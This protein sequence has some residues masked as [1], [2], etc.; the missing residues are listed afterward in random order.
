[1]HRKCLSSFLSNITINI[2]I[3][4]PSYYNIDAEKLNASLALLLLFLYYYT[5]M[6]TTLVRIT[7]FDLS[8]FSS[9]ILKF[10]HLSD[11]IKKNQKYANSI[12]CSQAVTYPST[13]RARHCLTSVIGREL[14][15]SM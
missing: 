13:N 11:K 5:K 4:V 9:L 8:F 10:L 14:V 1:M 7:F 2:H 3:W 6:Q 12:Q 15:C